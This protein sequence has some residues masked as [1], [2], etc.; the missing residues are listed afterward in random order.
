MATATTTASTS[1]AVPATRRQALARLSLKGKLYQKGSSTDALLKRVKQVRTELSEM[2]QDTVDVNSLKDICKELVTPALMLHKD[3]AVKA[4]VACCLADMLR[5]FAPNAPFTPAELRDIFQ[6]FV[7]QLTMPQAGLSKPNGPQYAEYFYLLESLSNVKSVVLVCD[8]QNADEIMT[9]YFKAFLDLARPDM[10]KN[11]EICMADVLVQLID[12]CV[13]LPSEVLELLLANF[14]PKAIKHNPSAHRLTVQVCSN[15]KDRL[16]KNVAQYFNEVMISATQEDDQDQRLESLQAAHS[17]IVQIN[18]VVPSLLLNVI[19]QLEEELRAE[20]VQLRVLATKVLGQ[21]FA[22]KPSSTAGESSDLARRYAGTWRAWLGRSKDKSSSLRVVWAECTKPLLVHH[23]ELRHDLTPIIENKLLEPDERVRAATAK[24]LGSLDYETALHHVQK[25]V[26]LKLA[27]RC[28]DKRNLVRRES[29]EAVGKLFDMAYSEIENNDPAAIQQF[30]W[31]PQEVF[32]CLYAA[33][34]DLQILVATTVE[35]YILPIPSNL[36]EDEAA[37]TNR[38]LLVIKYLQPEATK[39]LLRLSNLIY[40]RPS[41][42]D[43]FLDCCQEYN[44]GDVSPDKDSTVVK[45]AMADRIRRAANMFADPERAKTDLHALAKLNDTRIY[46]LIRTCF[47]PQTDLKTAVKA[48]N[49]ALRRIENANASILDTMTVFIRSSSYFILNRS[50]VPTLIKKLSYTPAARGKASSSQSQ[51]QGGEGSDAETNRDSAKELLEFIAKRCPAM[52]ALQVPELCKALFEESNPTLTQTCLQALASIAQWNTAKVQ[53]DKKAVERLAKLVL[54]G[55]ALQA[56]FASKLLAIVAT[57]GAKGGRKAAGQ[58]PGT[59]G[60]SVSSS[61]A[62]GVLEEVLDSLA[63]HLASA[64]PDGQVGVLY[65]LAQ[66]FKH[67]PDASENVSSTVVRTIL[68]DILLKPLSPSKAKLYS[69][70][71]SWVEDSNVDHELQTKLLSLTVLTRRCEAFAE[72]TSASDMAKPI[73][74]LLWAV[75]SAGEAKALNTPGGA[76]SRMR[77]QAAICVLKLA[78]HSSYDACIGREYLD[79]AFTIQDESFNVRSRIL[80]KLLTYLQARRIDG[81]FLAMAFLAAYDPEDEN[82]NMVIR[83]CTS[84]SCS[85]PAEQRLKLLDVSFP[86]L[87]HLLAHHPDF[88]SETKEDLIQFI[89]YLEFFLDSLCTPTNVSLFYYLASRVRGVR[90]AETQGASENLYALSELAQLVI[91]KRATEKGWTIESYP[92][93]V[94]LPGDIFKPLPSREVQKE[95]YARQYLPADLVRQL[96]DVKVKAG[97]KGVNGAGKWSMANITSGGGKKRKATTTAAARGK[98]KAGKSKKR[99]SSDDEDEVEEESEWSE[100]D[101]EEEKD[102]NQSSDLSEVE[103]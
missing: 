2:E 14:T 26:L 102:G 74:R 61:A 20:D 103:D 76:K 48:R 34:I 32:K 15:T 86:R 75:I 38:L 85:L 69:T 29:L 77:L 70:D 45:I 35:K 66:L 94:T 18:R 88:S 90:D 50:A 81:R 62:F 5:L 46:R 52:L 89:R 24:M 58:K 73:F 83:Y 63:K 99:K 41:L 51:S 82:R 49:D 39:A 44:G 21:M 64:K 7:H 93:K 8:L 36:E 57:G 31:I 54:K 9:D 22:E 47:D 43:R 30:A 80:H 84:N 3:K 71:N 53:L 100:E 68:S 87:I 28:K 65:S 55:T 16:Q 4:N 6:F 96:S 56:K 91:R 25:S 23:P 97:G 19:P 33:Q 92:G 12:E 101:E 79:L 13:A 27:D 60:T 78:R 11:V 1:S 42:P 17:L 40:T 37:W 59:P 98:K 95:I 72:T 10:S 67:A